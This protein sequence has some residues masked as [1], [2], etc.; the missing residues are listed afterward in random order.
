[1]V[2]GLF[3]KEG[4]WAQAVRIMPHWQEVAG[5]WACL[6]QCTRAAGLPAEGSCVAELAELAAGDGPG[7]AELAG[8]G[9]RGGGVWE[10]AGVHRCSRAGFPCTH[11]ASISRP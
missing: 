1:M 6:S 5:I 11:E 7:Q 3:P 2:L 8:D 9:G 4:S 10:G